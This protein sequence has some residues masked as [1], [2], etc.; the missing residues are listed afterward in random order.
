MQ[1]WLGWQGW[2]EERQLWQPPQLL[3]QQPM[4]LTLPK[5]QLS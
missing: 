5:L 2:K 4:G 3:Q 1:P